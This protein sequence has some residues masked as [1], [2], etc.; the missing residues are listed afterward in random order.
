M[1]QLM[2]ALLGRI[3]DLL[4]AAWTAVIVLLGRITYNDNEEILKLCV[5]IKLYGHYDY[6]Q[7][8]MFVC[9]YGIFAYSY[10]HPTLI[11]KNKMD[12]IR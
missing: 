4:L 10:L 3:G 12:Y 7:S 8:S 11:I 2:V 9:L 6:S 1:T 5:I